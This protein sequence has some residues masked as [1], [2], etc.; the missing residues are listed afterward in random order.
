VAFSRLFAVI[1]TTYGAGDGST[2][3]NVPDL[4]GR[5][6]AGLDADNSGPLTPAVFGNN[7]NFPGLVGGAQ[8][9]TLVEANLPSHV[10]GPGSLTANTVGNHSHGGATGSE[11]ATHTHSGTTGNENSSLDHT[12]QVT[13]ANSGASFKDGTG[14]FILAV[15]VLN[16]GGVASGSLTHTH[17]FTTGGQSANHQHAIS[18]DG[19]HNHSISSGTTAATG[20]GTAHANVQPTMIMHYIIKA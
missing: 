5:V 10:H 19:S 8:T 11:N 14:G 1:G 15:A 9:N 4:Q 17:N 16:T 20:S 12:H 6:I 3:F 13:A 18:A 2:T 7:V